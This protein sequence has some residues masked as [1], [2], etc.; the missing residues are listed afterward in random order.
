VRAV[1]AIVPAAGLSRRMGGPNKLLLPWNDTTMVG[2]VVRTLLACG[3]DVVVVTGRDAEVVGEAARGARTVFNTRFTE[4]LGSSIS[5]G[6]AACPKAEGFLITLGDMPSLDATAVQAVVE[7][8]EEAPPDAIIAAVYEDDPARLGHPVLF[9]ASYREALLKLSGDVG[10][11]A[12]LKCAIDKVI[13]VPMRGHLD[14]LD[15][16]ADLEA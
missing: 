7:Q 4:G 9:G 13:R 2:A 11:R 1:S 12:I 14:D 15:T 6:V 5:A 16:A 10:A 3:L 8:F